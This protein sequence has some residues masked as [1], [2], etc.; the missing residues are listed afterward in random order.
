MLFIA[1]NAAAVFIAL[2]SGS[3]CSEN[4]G[5]FIS[6][7]NA[8]APLLHAIAATYAQACASIGSNPW[9][10]IIDSKFNLISLQ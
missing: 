4:N 6:I 9:R 10:V 1:I 5:L 2:R 8:S 3:A 7:S